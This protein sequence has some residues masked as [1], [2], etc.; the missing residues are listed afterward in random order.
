M[1]TAEPIRDDEGADIAGPR[2]A[3][4]ERQNPFTGH[5]PASDHGTRPNLKRSFADSHIRI[6]EGGWARE[7]TVR[8]VPISKSTAGVNMRLKA[9]A[10]RELHW[11]KE[12]EWSYM[13][14]GTG[15]AA[16][17]EMGRTFAEDV[18]E[19]DLWYF[20]PG[21]L[22]SIQGSDSEIDGC[23]FLLG[24]GDGNFS[25]DSTFLLTDW[26][27][28]TPR[29]VLAKI[30]R[31]SEAK[32]KK[33]PSKELCIFPAPLPDA[34]SEDRMNGAGPVPNTFSHRLLRQETEPDARRNVRI[35]DTS[36]FAASRTIAVALVE[37]EPGG[38]RELHWH[39]NVDE[40]QYYIN[41]EGRMTVFGSESKTY[42]R[43]PRR[44]RRLCPVRHGPLHREHGIRTAAFFGDVPKRALC[45]PLAQPV[46]RADAARFG[47]C[48]SEDRPRGRFRSVDGKGARAAEMTSLRKDMEWTI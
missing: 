20:P 14:K 44:R 25:E 18:C 6:E 16:V 22:H 47:R 7:T 10:F 8:E 40:W 30:F 46:A 15:I 27:A 17:D 13:P 1:S 36:S 2:N 39:P 43:L 12:A 11:H 38:L 37:L 45:R 26:L 32:L 28:H 4:R 5:W 23:E 3:D 24:F 19:G 21:I 34:L 42:V 31:R 35:V 41:G 29:D 33:L 9:G 48:P